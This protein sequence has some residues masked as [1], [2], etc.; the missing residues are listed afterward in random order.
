MATM[1][2]TQQ[3]KMR[4]LAVLS[5]VE[6]LSEQ[7]RM[8]VVMALVEGGMNYSD[9]FSLAPNLLRQSTPRE[10]LLTLVSF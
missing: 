8:Q 6:D 2:A 4:E 10:Q 1:A 5:K 3:N 7:E 9:I